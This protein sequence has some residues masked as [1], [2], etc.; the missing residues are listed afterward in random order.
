MHLEPLPHELSLRR[1][2]HL[3]REVALF[4]R[5][6]VR[7]GRA[8]R[9]RRRAAR[10]GPRVLVLPGLLADDISMW[11]LRSGLRARGFRAYRWG[12]G[13][14]LGVSPDLI[15]RLDARVTRLQ[16]R[17]GRPLVLV[18]WSLG[19]LIAREYAKRAPHR[20][21]AVITLGSPFSGDLSATLVS[22]LYRLV[23]GHR[24]SAASAALAL[25]EK[26]PVPTVAVWS[27]CD[28]VIPAASARGD[29][30]EA[31]MQIEVGCPHLGYP[32]HP[33]AL[34]AVIDAIEACRVMDLSGSDTIP[35][36]AAIAA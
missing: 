15:D 25:S 19:G 23:S 2:A 22:H 34:K 16:R 27:R 9:P 13:R 1:I 32:S 30:A 31:D 28:G 11:P 26:P 17:D 36:R 10:R 14:N 3:L 18:G 4:A 20:V 5:G 6:M 35:E 33:A 21:A 12:L 8:V 24:P 29:E 7:R